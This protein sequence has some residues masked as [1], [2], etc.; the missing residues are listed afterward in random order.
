MKL[1]TLKFASIFII[2]LLLSSNGCKKNENDQSKMKI[3]I[4]FLMETYDLDR[5]I[6]DEQAFTQRANKLGGEVFRAVA[7]GDQDRQ[8]NQADGFLTKGVNAL[9]VVPRNLGTAARIVKSAHEK[10]VPV[11]AYDRLIRDSD[12]D[13]Y[14]TFDNEKVGYLQAKGILEKVPEGNFILLGG[15]A[16]DNNARLL[17]AGQLRAI[18]EY[19]S[20]TKKQINILADPFMDNW[21]RDDARRRISSMLTMFK[22]QGKIVNAI[23]ASNDATAGGVV[24]ALMAEQMQGKIAVSGQDAELQAC[25]RIVEGTQAVTIYKPVKQLAEVS[26]EVAV[27]LALGEKPEAIAKRLGFT[28]QKINNGYKDVPSIFLEPVFVTKDNINETVIKDGWQTLEKV[29]SGLPKDQW[30]K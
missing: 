5:W 6:R 9:V 29:Y 27:G 20:S 14:V 1:F 2:I 21:D 11:V 10:N 12:V 26:A 17:R 24:A 8:N 25:Q 13:M 15:A 23:I 3:K 28:L 7:D 30:K 16:S 18:K 19:Q 22:A 4:G